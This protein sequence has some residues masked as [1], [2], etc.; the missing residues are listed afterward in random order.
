MAI[1]GSAQICDVTTTV[2]SPG[3]A[4]TKGDESDKENEQKGLSLSVDAA[5]HEPSEEEDNAAD[6]QL[7]QR[8]L[9]DA[10]LSRGSISSEEHQKMVA[11]AQPL[12]RSCS[13]DWCRKWPQLHMDTIFHQ[14]NEAEAKPDAA[15][16]KEPL[17]DVPPVVRNAPAAVTCQDAP[18]DRKKELRQRHLMAFASKNPSFS[19]ASSEAAMSGSPDGTPERPVLARRESGGLMRDMRDKRCVLCASEELPLHAPTL[20][21]TPRRLFPPG[22]LISW[23]PHKPS[24]PRRLCGSKRKS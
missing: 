7:Q 15:A 16:M 24:L 10:K 19:E 12:W 5:V 1:E 17:Q 3:A 4:A 14:A 2:S 20:P 23:Q 11:A 8:S 18:R 9:L 6:L 22:S 21:L 13:T